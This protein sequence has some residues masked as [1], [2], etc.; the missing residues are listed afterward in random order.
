MLSGSDADADA[1]A[2]E[3]SCSG[4]KVAPGSG[5][6]WD[7]IHMLGVEQRPESSSRR[8]RGGGVCRLG[9]V[10]RPGNSSGRRRGM[11]EG[12]AHPAYELRAEVPRAR[13]RQD[14]HH[15]ATAGGGLC[16]PAEYVK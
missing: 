9:E 16:P 8:Q 13:H 14:V 5:G 2:D 6:C 7:A 12:C 3:G 10:Q 4:R 15:G 11:G 1:D